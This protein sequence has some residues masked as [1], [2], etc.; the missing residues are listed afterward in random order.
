[1]TQN[2]IKFEDIYL[3]T[4]EQ[5][6]N[7]ALRLIKDVQHSE[8][9]TMKVFAKIDKLNKNP[10]TH[11]DS[12]KSSLTTWVH[13]ITNGVILDY[14]R[15]NKSN[16]FKNVSDF[17]NENDPKDNFE[18]EASKQSNSDTD[19]LNK[20]LKDKIDNAF[21]TLKPDYLKIAILYFNYQYT[22]TEIAKI[23]N[24]PM[25]TVKAMLSRCRA[26]LQTE[27]KDLKKAVLV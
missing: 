4:N 23:L 9:V 24:V 22:Y 18:F 8:D 13:M 27:L 1:M 15:T 5:V 11:F 3:Q 12:K 20:E 10:L 14:F 2:K 19:I 7:H 6:L 26:M 25:G 17:G 21:K 16:K